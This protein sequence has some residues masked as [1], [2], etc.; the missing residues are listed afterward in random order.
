[1]L[2]ASRSTIGSTNNVDIIILL[3]SRSR[4]AAP[5]NVVGVVVVVVLS[6]SSLVAVHGFSFLKTPIGCEEGHVVRF[7]RERHRS[8]LQKKL[9]SGEQR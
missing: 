5:R 9:A 8:S 2:D 3:P 7:G 1:M 6:T 4:V